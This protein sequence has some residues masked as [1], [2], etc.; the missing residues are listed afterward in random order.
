M[1]DPRCAL[2]KRRFVV[3]TKCIGFDTKHHMEV[4]DDR[5][6]QFNLLIKNNR[7]QCF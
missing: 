1:L 5:A 6:K 2:G 3:D 4:F 7:D